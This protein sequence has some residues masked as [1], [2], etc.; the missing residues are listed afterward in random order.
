MYKRQ[1]VVWS[2]DVL[3]PGAYEIM[4]QLVNADGQLVGAMRRYSDMGSVD[5]DTAFDAV[6]PDV[7]WN[8]FLDVFTLVW[9]ADDDLGALTDGRFEVYGQLVKGSSGNEG[10]ANDFR[11][12]YS[13][14]DDK[15]N[16]VLEPTVA[17]E[18]GTE[19]WFVAF[20]ADISDDGIHQSEIWMYGCNADLPDGAG[21]IVSQAGGS[22]FD[23]VSARNPDLAWV[24]SSS[25]LVCVWEAEVS[26]IDPQGIF[27][28]R[29]DTAG[30]VLGGPIYFS[31]GAGV[32][33][34]AFL[35]AIYP[36]ITV[37]PITDEWFVAWRGALN[38]GLPHFDHEVWARRFD[39][40]GNPVDTAAFQLSGMDPS[41][42]PV[43]GAG[44]P[45]VAINGTHGYKLIAWS[46][47][48]DSTPGDEHEIFVQAWSD[49]GASPVDETPAAKAF[50]LHGAAP[51]PFN[52]STT[53]AFDLPRA[54]TVN[55]TIYDASGRVV[56]RLLSQGPGLAGRNE[57][58]WNGRDEAGR[59]VSSG[60]YL[61]TLETPGHRDKGR[62]TLVK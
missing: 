12:T 51:N 2:S 41:L 3:N 37:D 20:E 42:G 46:G 13:L 62:M 24:P 55:L 26:G 52:P 33:F 8:S 25:E 4:G 6:T 58:V 40:L 56:R 7:A 38:N 54:A 32:P 47:D 44:A 53:I 45:A 11:I 23:D 50:A 60:V 1:L 31:D 30:N 61:Y 59:Q 28:Q 35:E 16:D 21:S 17:V 5:T 10:G 57:V 27:G 36:S 39:D 9:A 29:L 49:D 48:L 19:R 22:I 34:G 43:A 14:A 15:G 18:P